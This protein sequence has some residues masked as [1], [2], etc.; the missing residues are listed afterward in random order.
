MMVVAPVQER[1]DDVRLKA[2]EFVRERQSL[3]G[4]QVLRISGEW[5]VGQGAER[6][7]QTVAGVI[8]G[9][10]RSL[11]V[12]I[13]DPVSRTAVL[14]EVIHR[15]PEKSIHY[16]VADRRAAIVQG[17]N[18]LPSLGLDGVINPLAMW[19][20]VEQVMSDQRSTVLE[21]SVAEGRL[22]VETK[23][24][25]YTARFDA[26]TRDLLSFERR[27][28]SSREGIWRTEVRLSDYSAIGSGIRWPAAF[29][30][31]LSEGEAEA[32]GMVGVVRVQLEEQ[33]APPEVPDLSGAAVIDDFVEQRFT[34]GRG[35][36]RLNPSGENAGTVTSWRWGNLWRDWGSTMLVGG[37][38]GLVVLAGVIY[39]RR[40]AA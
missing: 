26:V 19:A 31:V 5:R 39:R 21:F 32:E 6:I 10:W 1:G 20:Q 27:R 36:P 16:T 33:A 14:Q 3:R 13:V 11:Q 35:Q 4:S 2:I 38:V 24:W 37:G 40:A 18:K 7:E 23:A 17:T 34:D 12:S 15:T 29:A 30:T 8:A 28:T 25:L 22:R 9:A